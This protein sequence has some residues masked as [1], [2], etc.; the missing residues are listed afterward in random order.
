MEYLLHDVRYS[1]RSLLKRPGFALVVVMT[2]ALGIGVNT[3]IFSFV[4]ALLLR[5]LPYRDP[6]RL[7]RI[8]SMRGNE[9]GRLSMI[10]LKEIREQL[11]SIESIGPYLPGAQYNYS[12]DGPPE[13]LSAVLVSRDFFTVLGVPQLQGQ[14]WP[15][16]YD[17]ERNFGVVLSHELWKRRFGGD[18][19][20]IGRKITLDAAPF[21]TIY[22]VMPPEFNFP[23]ST[24][25]FRSIAINPN[26]PNYTDRAARR[27]YALARLK[28]GVSL[29]Q[30]RAELDNFSAHLAR[31]HSDINTGLTFSIKPLRDFYVGDVRP[32]LW[33]LAGAVGFVLL[34]ACTNVASLLL[35]HSLGRQ[36]EVA[37]R[38]ALGASRWRMLRQ[39]LTESFLL[40][41]GGGLLGLA[42]AWLWMR[43][44]ASLIRVQL[45][46]WV[47]VG[48]D[49]RVLTFTLIA[50]VLTGAVAGILPALQAS[51][52]DFNELLKE[53]AKG[54][55]GGRQQLRQA[56]VVAEVAL[57]L[58]LLIGAG[59]M[60]KSFIRLQQTELGFNPERLLTMRVALP[61]RKYNDDSGP[62]RAKL[63]FKQL[64]ERLNGL[65][66]V[67]SAALTSNLPLSGE[68]Q[69]G[70]ST[71]TV[72]G[73]S[74]A[75]QQR[76]P[77]LNDLR[78]SP[79]YL[80]AMGI[81][82]LRGRFFNGSDTAKTDRVGVVSRRLA[83]RLWPGQDPI[84]KRLKVGGLDSKAQW[85]TIIGVASDV[86]HEQI[87]GDSGLDLYVSYQQVLDSSMYLLLRTKVSPETLA[88]AATKAVWDSDPEQSTFNIVTMD[89]RVAD[90]V[91]QR[92]LSGTLVLIF[93][94]LALVL[95]AV[96][97]YGVMS[98]AVRQRTRE[99]GIRIAM[100][101]KPADVMRLVIRQG[102]KLILIGV[103]VGLMF[104]FAV[105][106][107][108]SSLLYSVSPTDP[109]TYLS[110]PFF[111]TVVGLTACLIPAYRATRVDPIVALRQQ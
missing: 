49:W 93:A 77:Y 110:V 57:A 111:L 33:L 22:G 23:A 6:E 10:E 94:G 38:A 92:R 103:S 13:E 43:L 40:S 81:A 15:E 21:Y 34:I 87:A 55:T 106:R 70:K 30:A 56:F 53:G 50:S 35:T 25:L 62:E 45:P 27:V 108:M 46:S 101:A 64:I 4:N 82:L 1:L 95:A 2:L 60:V 78:V 29:E 109:L 63:F 31:D 42:F 20:V 66:G 74:P 104:A 96:R 54:S 99:L 83:E 7:V 26:L 71:F 89:T 100:G 19:N 9:E 61:W 76:N 75:E 16:S 51:R 5:P 73:Q 28:P 91:W 14:T 84:G 98:Y 102:A 3:A 8:T 18:P 47:K 39:L 37:V 32:Y 105:T 72:E 67:E 12:G 36:R 68:T 79:A 24:Q 90:T 80:Q 69:E 11:K 48:I 97:I 52:P 107:I 58:V 41:V 65:S 88:E 86:K 17:L 85:T 59:L 44:L